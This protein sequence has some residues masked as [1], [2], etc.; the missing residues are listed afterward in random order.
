MVFDDSTIK[1]P[2]LKKITHSLDLGLQ[3]CIEYTC[4]LEDK[5]TKFLKCLVVALQKEIS[6]GGCFGVMLWMSDPLL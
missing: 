3:L 2:N 1:L 5:V 6:T 4:S